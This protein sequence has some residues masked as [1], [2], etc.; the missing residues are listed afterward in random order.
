MAGIF[1]TQGVWCCGADFLP[2]GTL[3][4]GGAFDAILNAPVVSAAWARFSGKGIQF[5]TNSYAG[6]SFNVN[7]A[8]HVGG[9]AFLLPSLPVGSALGSIA[10]WMDTTAGLPQATLGVNAQGQL[11]FYQSGGL[12]IA[13]LASPIGPA[14]ATGVIVP[15]AYNFIEFKITINNVTG[16]LECR[17]NGTVVITFTG[18][19]KVTANSYVNQIR[20]GSLTTTLP[21]MDDLYLLD[22]TAPSP[23]DT[24]L[25]NGRIQTDGPNA[26]SATGGLNAWAFTT[27]QG[28]D[29]ANAANIPANPAQYDS[30]AVLND[31]MSFRF[32]AIT[33]AKVL[34]LNSW[35]SAEQD[36]AGTRG[37]TPIYRS[38]A[39]DQ[40]GGAIALSNGTFVHSNQASVLDPNTAATWA[41]GTVVAAG[42]CEIG[43]KTTS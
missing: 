11:Q 38:N 15:G 27:P 17:V 41:A 14:S 6:R 32:P 37:I 31:R 13:G 33:A 43:V 4:A 1:Q 36:A 35:I 34:F 22:T 8:A 18:N 40:V 21:Q 19:T 7:L 29:F 10:T 16:L 9:F 25:G 24:Y 28:S 2:N 26:G 30:D 5:P 12:G 39:V 42:S 20:I 23:L 3:V